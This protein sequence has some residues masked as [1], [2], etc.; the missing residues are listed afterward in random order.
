MTARAFQT[1]EDTDW[2][3]HAPPQPIRVSTA[4]IVSAILHRA[5]AIGREY[6]HGARQRAM[7]THGD[8]YADGYAAGA[9]DAVGAM[10]YAMGSLVG[11]ELAPD[12]GAD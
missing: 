3:E 1:A 6:A 8:S 7:L 11:D 10:A 2:R 12:P 5:I 9:A 4:R